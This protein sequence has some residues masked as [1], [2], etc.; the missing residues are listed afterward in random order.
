MAILWCLLFTSF[1]V[2]SCYW[3]TLL[4]KLSLGKKKEG[5]GEILTLALCLALRLELIGFGGP[6]QGKTASDNYGYKSSSSE[7]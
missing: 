6:H 1:E 2:L 4:I 5:G 3:N 7:T